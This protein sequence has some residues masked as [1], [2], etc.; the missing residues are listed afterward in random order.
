MLPLSSPNHLKSLH[1]HIFPNYCENSGSSLTSNYPSIPCIPNPIVIGNVYH[2]FGSSFEESPSQSVCHSNCS[3]TISSSQQT[4]SKLPGISCWSTDPYS[5]QI[6]RR[7][8]EYHEMPQ[9]MHNIYDLNNDNTND[10]NS[11]NNDLLV[12][13]DN[14]IATAENN[15]IGDPSDSSNDRINR[16]LDLLTRKVTE[17]AIGG[18]NFSCIFL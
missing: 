11:S 2:T 8:T 3:T 15:M 12:F 17:H 1:Q 5:H 13:V 10:N 6:N 4:D 16:D 7:Q 9:C 14:Y 18:M